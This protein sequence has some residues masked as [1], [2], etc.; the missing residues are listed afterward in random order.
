MLLEREIIP[1]AGQTVNSLLAGYQVS[2]T[3][4]SDLLRTQLSFFQ[5]QAQYWQTLAG[6][7]QLLAELSAEVGEELDHD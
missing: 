3:D 1:E 5:Y 7:Q 4:F 6:T 2:R